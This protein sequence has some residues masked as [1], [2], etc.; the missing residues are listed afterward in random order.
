MNNSNEQF[1]ASPTF[2]DL[3]RIIDTKVK[4]TD[5]YQALVTDLQAQNQQLTAKLIAAME[6]NAK[7]RE[8][9]NQRGTQLYSD[10]A[11]SEF[12]RVNPCKGIKLPT[13]QRSIVESISP[14]GIV[15][16]ARELSDYDP[17]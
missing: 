6:E 1:V 5:S 14:T 4:L 2:Y 12:E 15:A 10:S 3:E 7:L 17:F 11:Y 9:L 13:L 8:Q 16:T